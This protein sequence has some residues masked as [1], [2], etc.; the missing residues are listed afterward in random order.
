MKH[1]SIAD[2]SQQDLHAELSGPVFANFERR[3]I[4]EPSKSGRNDSE[5][6]DLLKPF[7]RCILFISTHTTGYVHLV[8]HRSIPT[9]VKN[10]AR[11]ST[12][13]CNGRR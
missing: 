7:L 2:F 4:C 12:H 1:V 13:G 11:S 10:N 3:R 6:E 8:A 9:C 5:L